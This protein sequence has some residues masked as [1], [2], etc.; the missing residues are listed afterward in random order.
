MSGP[1]R[2][3]FYFICWK[4][5]FL[6]GYQDRIKELI[7]PAI[8]S[9]SMEL[10]DVECLKMKTRWLVRLFIDKE[11]GVTLDDCQK[12][13]H[14]VG[15]ILDVHE[16]PPGPYTLEV[17]SPGL[18]RPLTRDKDFLRFKGQKVGIKTGEKIEGTKNFHGRLMDYIEEQGE[19]IVVVEVEGKVYRIPREKIIKAH[20][21][22]QL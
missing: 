15:D 7:G 18:D 2:P 16:M 19:K 9:E 22:Y 17:S 14:L 4:V 10:V 13:S 6:Q 12:I 1:F 20:L 5:T 21:E 8:Q 11:R 3:L